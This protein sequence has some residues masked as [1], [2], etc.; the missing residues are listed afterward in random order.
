MGGFNEC[1]RVQVPAALHLCR[2]GYTYFAE[3]GEGTP[4]GRLDKNN[5]VLTDEFLKALV[6]LNPER[7]LHEL[8]I[9]VKYALSKLGNDDLGREF[10]QI[11]SSNSGIKLIDFENPENNSWLVTTELSYANPETQDSSL[12]SRTALIRSVCTIKVLDAF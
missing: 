9:F 7:K 10:Y 8:E 2:L 12:P 5:N 4:V 1:T 6:R 11:L 3:Y